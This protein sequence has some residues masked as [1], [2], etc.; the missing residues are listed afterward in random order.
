MQHY[1][2]NYSTSIF[3]LMI[4]K[5]IYLRIWAMFDTYIKLPFIWVSMQINETITLTLFKIFLYLDRLGH[6]NS[7]QV[8]VKVS[9]VNEGLCL[10]LTIIFGITYFSRSCSAS[11]LKN[12][13]F[14]MSLF[15]IYTTG[16]Y[17]FLS[18]FLKAKEKVH[19]FPF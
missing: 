6:L 1:A 7:S 3:N 11:F 2:G 10:P 15:K 12:Q 18:L 9:G 13:V 4:L 5:Y 19:K 8:I 14:Y 17:I 16:F